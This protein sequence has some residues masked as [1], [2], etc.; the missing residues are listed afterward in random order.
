LKI[1]VREMAKDKNIF[2][3]FKCLKLSN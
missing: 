1:K 3:I 2:F